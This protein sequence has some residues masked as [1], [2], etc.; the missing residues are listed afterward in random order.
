MQDKPRILCVDDESNVLEGLSQNLRRRF[1]VET[2]LGS[3]AA[4]ATLETGKTFAV[5]VSDMRMPGMNGAELLSRTRR[6]HPAMVRV[7]LTGYAEVESAIAA[8][9]EGNIFRFLTKPCP[10][11]AL[12]RALEDA[13]EQHRLITAERVLLEQTLHGSIQLLTDALTLVHP[14]A[15]GRANR[16]K[17]RVSE[18][19]TSLALPHKW[20]LEVAAMLSQICLVTL[21]PATLE[22]LNAGEALSEH[23]K[24]MTARLP[25]VSE[26]LLAGIPR[27]DEVRELLRFA[28]GRGDAARKPGTSPEPLGAAALR[29][30]L[31]LD[32]LES[33]GL[34]PALALETLRGRAGHYPEP[35]L[36]SLRFMLGEGGAARAVQELPVKGLAVG[37]V[38]AEEVRTA[39]GGLLIASG[40]ELTLSLLERLK[41]FAAGVG[42][43]EPVRVVVGRRA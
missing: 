7:L 41:N 24:A 19:A 38:L 9:N 11:E 6:S 35:V 1:A 20:Q 39:A 8:V 21:P 25:E 32:R 15:F 37:M 2:A 13:V 27:L 23:E 26:Q 31:D 34:S 17:Q 22:K 43:K 10:P 30:A 18:L 42:I 12:I 29:A 16:V 5:I 14:A 28:L 3:Q 33:T 36:E 4:L 40:Q